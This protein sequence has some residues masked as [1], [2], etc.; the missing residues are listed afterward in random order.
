MFEKME[1]KSLKRWLILAAVGYVL[2]PLDL[3]PDFL[4]IP[5]RL[6]DVA[7]MA[8]LAWFYRNHRRQYAGNEPRRDRA[9]NDGAGRGSSAD[10]TRAKTFDA[11]EVLQVGPSASPDA[12]RAAYL[13][14]MKEYHPDRVAHLGEELQKL[15]HEKA[16]EIQRAY[17]QLHK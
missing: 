2:L 15:A 16:Q 9:A 11:H 1:P 7:M 12:I 5:G 10:P 13:A 6:D 4:G 3:V 14:R 17:Q 8:L